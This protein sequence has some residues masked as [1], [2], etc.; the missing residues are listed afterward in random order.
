MSKNFNELVFKEL[1]KKIICG[2]SKM[3]VLC[4]DANKVDYNLN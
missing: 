1:N 3:L 2:Y 4:C